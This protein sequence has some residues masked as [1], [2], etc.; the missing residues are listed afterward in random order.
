M[1][2]RKTQN[3]FYKRD[4]RLSPAISNT[5]KNSV[6]AQN[7]LTASKNAV[8][9]VRPDYFEEEDIEL[10]ANYGKFEGLQ[11]RGDS[12]LSYIEGTSNVKNDTFTNLNEERDRMAKTFNQTSGGQKFLPQVV[13]TPLGLTSVAG[14]KQSPE[15]RQTHL[16]KSVYNFGKQLMEDYKDEQFENK[17]ARLVTQ[18]P[19]GGGKIDF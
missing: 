11:K 8:L 7:F 15:K 10:N 14:M 6:G 12:N 18:V 3:N 19:K 2:V 9:A 4:T 13:S 17:T 16:D 5:Y 1:S